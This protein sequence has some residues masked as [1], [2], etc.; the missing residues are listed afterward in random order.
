[1][2]PARFQLRIGEAESETGSILPEAQEAVACF[3]AAR[4][5]VDDSGD[6]RP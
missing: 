1:M 5:A 3:R 2:P 6:F 4:S